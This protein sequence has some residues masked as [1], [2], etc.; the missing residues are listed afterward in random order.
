MHQR[1]QE[2]LIH[3]CLHRGDAD[4]GVGAM[5]DIR[6]PMVGDI[7]EFGLAQRGYE[8]VGSLH[9]HLVIRNAV[10]KEKRRCILAD[11]FRG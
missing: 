8:S 11:V 5:V 2:E 6:Q 1:P 7:V 10:D 4:E 9:G 3:G